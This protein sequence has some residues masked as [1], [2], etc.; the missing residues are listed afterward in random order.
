[1][2]GP[3][4]SSMVEDVSKRIGIQV[5]TEDVELAWALCRCLNINSF[6]NRKRDPILKEG[7][8]QVRPSRVPECDDPHKPLVRDLFRGESQGPRVYG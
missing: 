7:F 4:Y 6:E 5:N 3:Y 1:M 8:V 2:E